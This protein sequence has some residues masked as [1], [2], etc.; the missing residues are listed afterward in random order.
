[1]PTKLNVIKNK[2]VNEGDIDNN[3]KCKDAVRNATN[4]H[5]QCLSRRACGPDG[6]IGFN[7]SRQLN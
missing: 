5:T 2:E 1:M 3:F 7:I 6:T 4:G